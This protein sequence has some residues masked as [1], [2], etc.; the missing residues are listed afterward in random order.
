MSKISG[1]VSMYYLKPISNDMPIIL[2]FG[3]HHFS[4]DHMCNKGTRRVQPLKGE[5]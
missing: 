4:Y 3:D 5:A 2:L 1:P